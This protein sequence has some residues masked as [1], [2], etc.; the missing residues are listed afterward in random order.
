MQAGNETIILQ[1]QH[2]ATLLFRPVI[3]QDLRYV[4]DYGRFIQD[5][6]MSVDLVAD[7]ELR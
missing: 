6:G 5:K 3:I 1:L 7:F 2:L 4:G